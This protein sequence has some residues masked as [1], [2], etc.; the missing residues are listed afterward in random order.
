M[1]CCWNRRPGRLNSHLRFSFCLSF[2][3]SFSVCCYQ[4]IDAV[5]RTRWLL[6]SSVTWRLRFASSWSRVTFRR[7]RVTCRTVIMYLCTC[8]SVHTND[9]ALFLDSCVLVQSS[10]SG[11]YLRNGNIA[12]KGLG[13]WGKFWKFPSPF[14]L[15][16]K[17][18]NLNKCAYCQKRLNRNLSQVSV[19]PTH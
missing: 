5:P 16:P 2:V 9:A 15:V 14:Q 4:S 1:W 6:L 11:Y 3:T 18:S 8:Y 12:H 13:T 17:S 7:F 10:S 19:C